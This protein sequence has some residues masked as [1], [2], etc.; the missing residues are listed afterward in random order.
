MVILLQQY[1]AHLREVDQL[2]ESA[3]SNFSN[4]YMPSELI[5]ASEWADFENV[6]QVHAPNLFMCDSV[7]DV[8]LVIQKIIISLLSNSFLSSI[9]IAQEPVV[10]LNI[11]WPLG[12]ATYLQFHLRLTFS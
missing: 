12:Q 5:S 9:I 4:Y 1:I 10:D 11:T 8:S 3:L 6:Y 7:R 2:S